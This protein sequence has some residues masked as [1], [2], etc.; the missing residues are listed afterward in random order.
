VYP[1]AIG[2]RRW[3]W[4]LG[5]WLAM[6]WY[7]AMV[8]GENFFMRLTGEIKRYGFYTTRFVEASRREDAEHDALDR[9]KN[10][11]ELRAAVL[12]AD[13][14]APELFIEELVEVE[15]DSVPEDKGA[16]FSFYPRESDA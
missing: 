16:G 11:A 14:I 13:N 6:P 9:I 5:D 1:Y 7:R 10:D 4:T 8:R 2:A 3:P 15:A 12:N